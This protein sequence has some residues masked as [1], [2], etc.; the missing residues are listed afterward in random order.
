MTTYKEISPREIQVDEELTCQV[1]KKLRDNPVAVHSG[2]ESYLEN[3][4]L[5]ATTTAETKAELIAYRKIRIQNTSPAEVIQGQVWKCNRKGVYS[6]HITVLLDPSDI[7]VSLFVDDEV[8]INKFGNI[9][10]V[11]QIE[12][13]FWQELE[14]DVNQEVRI[15]VS[16]SGSINSAVV[17]MYAYAD[18]RFGD[19]Q[20]VCGLAT[21]HS[22]G[23]GDIGMGVTLEGDEF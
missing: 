7:D 11:N 23:T 13:D 16:T 15:V 1:F 5:R 2:N 3:C 6:I 10:T 14:L 20:V 4:F 21:Y 9:E 12:W 18:Q 17:N 19:Y 22:T 8:V